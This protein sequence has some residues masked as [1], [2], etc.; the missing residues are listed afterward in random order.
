MDCRVATLLAMTAKVLAALRVGF[1]LIDLLA[2]VGP[3][4]R[5]VDG[6]ELRISF[7][8]LRGL[9]ELHFRLAQEIKAVGGSLAP[10]VGSIIR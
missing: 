9:P 10:R 2:K 5:A 3:D 7:A 1:G 8:G 6:I 4:L